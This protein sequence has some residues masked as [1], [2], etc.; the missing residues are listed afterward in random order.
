MGFAIFGMMGLWISIVYVE[1]IVGCKQVWLRYLVPSGIG[2]CI[3]YGM[4]LKQNESTRS[5]KTVL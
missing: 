4:H 1:Y 3:F 2:F 5:E